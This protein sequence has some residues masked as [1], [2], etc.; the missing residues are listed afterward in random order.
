VSKSAVE[1]KKKRI[2]LADLRLERSSV[3]ERGG[4]GATRSR[5]RDGEE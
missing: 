1:K 5:G 4:K 2:F 3:T